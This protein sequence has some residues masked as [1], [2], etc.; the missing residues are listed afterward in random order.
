MFD[1]SIRRRDTHSLCRHVR[2]KKYFLESFENFAAT[3]V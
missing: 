3:L 2:I 1:L